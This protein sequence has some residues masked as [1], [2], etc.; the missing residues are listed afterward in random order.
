MKGH[1]VDAALAATA[2]LVAAWPISTLLV[3]PTWV[4]G[5]VM[6]LA[7]IAI[8]G[9]G[10]RSLRLDGWQ[11]V[12]TQLA[13]AT[14]AAAWVYGRGHLW[15]GLPYLE[16]LRFADRRLTE[17]LNALHVYAAPAP[18][19]P[20]LIFLVGCSMALIAIA[21]D[22]L[23][24]TR[25][26][27]SLAG[28]PLLTAF[29]TSAANSGSSLPVTFFAVTAAMWLIMVGRQGS[30][31]LRRWAT[32]M[33]VARTPVMAS[34]DS[35]GVYG[36]ASVARALGLA[37]LVAA[38]AV[39]VGL[40]HLNPTFLASGLGRSPLASGNVSGGVGFSLSID[41]AED[42]KEPG[43][44]PVLQYKTDDPSPPPLRVSVSSYYR[45]APGVWLPG[46]GPE[47][48]LSSHPKVPQPGGLLPSVP[49]TRFTMT[50]SHNRLNDPNLAVPFP[51][52][53]AQMNGIEWGAGT[54][55]QNVRVAQRPDSYTAS[56]WKLK[57]TA[58][59]LENP[60]HD[61]ILDFGDVSGLFDVNMTLDGPSAGPV[62][63]LSERLTAGKTS[64][65]DKA[66]AIQQYLRVAGGFTYSLTLAPPAR[67][68]SGKVAGYD[69]LTNFLVT[70]QGYCV[71]FA[72]AMVMMSRAAGIPAHIAVGFTPG[73]FAKGV[74]T[75]TAADAH[76][77]PELYLA[78]L[79]WTRFEPTPSRAAPP[80]Y[81]LPATAAGGAAGSETATGSTTAPGKASPRQ[82]SDRVAGD[83]GAGARTTVTS[84]LRWLTYGRGLALL[85][86]TLGLLGSLVVPTAAQWR[87]RR[88]L[89]AARTPAQRVE[90]QWSLLT[91]AMSDLGIARAPSRTPRQL[92]AYYDREA[93]LQ[94]AAS[95]ALG[96]VVGTLQDARYAIPGQV[97]DGFGADAR[98][99]YRAAAA[100]RRPGDRVRA[101]LWSSDGLAQL[102]TM[103]DSLGWQLR[104][105]ARYLNN[106]FERRFRRRRADR[107]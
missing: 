82:Q 42:L 72:T 76:A 92:R 55:V 97:P 10:A 19:T 39:P 53:D 29:L 67:D 30:A 70:K 43:S 49:K 22:Y 69:P 24:V 48:T 20:G 86:F 3:D 101:S 7:A 103:R 5:T 65:F 85:T 14:L 16:T 64:T 74:W 47:P 4:G 91:S 44:S 59:F 6:L 37:A 32:A 105:P 107:S 12:V 45:S 104:A 34:R 100:G 99:V 33:A 1:G 61:P 9:V 8:S 87:R 54:D 83:G 88:K 46:S 93:R 62:T 50:A 21:V 94:G 57:P 26:S 95:E 31:V 18:S 84:R 102:R 63:A 23:A 68:R 40:P 77:W 89:I 66:M 80:G 27:P 90:V 17:A 71:Q 98:L 28:L 38:V 51:L 25:Q 79:G 13:S 35:Q 75:V 52:I 36:Y 106:S 58:A 15:H 11:V 2:T 78:G 81:A 41:L 56:Y 73:T 60:P 96:R